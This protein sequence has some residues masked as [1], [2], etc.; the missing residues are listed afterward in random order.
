MSDESLR[1]PGSG[2]HRAEDF[3]ATYVAGGAPWDIGRPQPALAAVAERG[4]FKGRVLDVGCGTGEHALL[5]ASLGLPAV[6]VD[7]AP[8]AVALAAAKA[9]E[10]GSDARFLVADAHDLA[11]LGEQ[12]DTVVDCGLFHVFDDED[13]ARYVASLVSVVPPG[14]RL[15]LLCFSDRQP[16]DF[17]PRRVSDAELRS[18]F[19]DGWR[20]DSIEPADLVV[21]FMPQ[22]ILAS[23]ATITRI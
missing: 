20:V 9:R 2:G 4:G 19:A 16:G 5:A 22:P 11:V 21:T 15:F 23:L 7:G 1:Q 17:G 8:T 6:G 10:R 13:R 12:F 14:G 3:E 18:S